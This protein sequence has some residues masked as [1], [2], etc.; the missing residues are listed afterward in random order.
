[1]DSYASVLR[2]VVKLTKTT[3]GGAHHVVALKYP[4]E[5]LGYSEQEEHRYSATAATEVE[6]CT[7]PKAAFHRLLR[8][9]HEPNQR[10]L[11]YNAREL[12]LAREWN[13]MVAC[14]SSYERVALFFMLI[15]KGVRNSGGVV[16]G[17]PETIIQLPLTRTEVADYLGLSL[18]TVSRTITKLK[19][20]GLIEFRTPREVII[21]DTGRLVAEADLIV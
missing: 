2:G 4:P 12:E 20:K 10:L 7:Y 18:E 13:L 9:G 21:S 15:A 3:A 5:F 11:E 16:E 6:L 17:E 19:R 14:K 1:V 8:D